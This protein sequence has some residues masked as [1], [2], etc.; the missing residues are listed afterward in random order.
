MVDQKSEDEISPP[1]LKSI[2]D[3]LLASSQLLNNVKTEQDCK[4]I[5]LAEWCQHIILINLLNLE[6]DDV[7]ALYE[8]FAVLP[9]IKR[10][11]DDRGRD[12]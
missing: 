11:I 4:I 7:I 5:I 10:I 12:T 2:C 9:Y 6:I 3:I 1:D 8:E